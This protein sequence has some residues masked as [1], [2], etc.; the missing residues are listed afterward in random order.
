MTKLEELEIAV[1]SLPEKEYSEF[2]RWF[3]ERDWAKWDT[4]VEED[5]RSGKLDFLVNEALDAKKQGKLR[6]L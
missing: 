4:Q 6:D 3:L 5:S 2:R 1:D